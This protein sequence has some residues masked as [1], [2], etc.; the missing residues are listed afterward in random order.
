M[1]STHEPSSD[2]WDR[3][4]RV[5]R[6]VWPPLLVLLCS[7]AVLAL[8][9]LRAPAVVRAAPVLTYVAV[10]PGLACVRLIGLPDRLTEFL[11]GVGLSLALGTLVALAMIYLRLWSP[12]LGVVA[13]GAIASIAAVTELLRGRLMPSLRRWPRPSS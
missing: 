7:G 5:A 12:T 6:D 8:V 3:L 4:G 9:M 11:L 13:L 2:P 10:V 1:T